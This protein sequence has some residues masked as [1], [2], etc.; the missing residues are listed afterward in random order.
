MRRRLAYVL[1]LFLATGL[2][3]TAAS[4]CLQK[5]GERCQIDEDCQSGVCAKGAG[6]CVAPG[7]AS[8]SADAGVDSHPPD[9]AFDASVDAHVDAT[10]DAP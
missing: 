10:P 6:I 8:G 3:A 1:A 2:A 4:G 5:N 9:A 7:S